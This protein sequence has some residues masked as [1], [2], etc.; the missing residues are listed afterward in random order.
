MILKAFIVVLLFHPVGDANLLHNMAVLCCTLA[1]E[2]HSSLY[3]RSHIYDQVKKELYYHP[4]N[5]SF[6]AVCSIVELKL[7]FYCMTPC[8]IHQEE[9]QELPDHDPCKRNV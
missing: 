3:V 1:T 4:Q 5:V 2:Q 6:Y 9:N 8:N 7:I